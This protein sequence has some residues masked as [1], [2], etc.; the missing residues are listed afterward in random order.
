MLRKNLLS[1]VAA[2]ALTTAL[3]MSAFAGGPTT[4]MPA[5]QAES[6][7]TLGMNYATFLNNNFVLLAGYVNDTFLADFGVNYNQFN[8]N[9]INRDAWEF[10]GDLGLRYMLKD[11]L[12]FT[13]GVN[14]AYVDLVNAASPTKAP[15]AVGGF[16][17]FDFQPLNHLLLSVKVD[18][19]MYV[20]HP[21]NQL[22]GATSENEVFS[23]GSI[24]AS[25]IFA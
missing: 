23:N 20:S 11:T 6:G 2:G 22:G 8:F 24:G 18:P 14:G 19:Y 25:Y 9:S 10:R 3:S 13:Y 5:Q 12:F 16:V 4:E 21:T 15:Y 1:L 7:F 17:G